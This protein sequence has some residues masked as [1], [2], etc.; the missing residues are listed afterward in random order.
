MERL[1][2]CLLSQLL[3]LICEK[4][5][6]MELPSC[7]KPSSRKERKKKTTK[8]KTKQIFRNGNTTNFTPSIK[9]EKKAECYFLYY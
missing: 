6:E 1:F 5:T 3:V 7:L 4:S 9:K 8:N 2:V